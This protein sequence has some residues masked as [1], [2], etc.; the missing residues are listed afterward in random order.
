M[1]VLCSNWMTT[2]S[3]Y[4]G[5]SVKLGYIRSGF[6]YCYVGTTSIDNH[7]QMTVNCLFCSMFKTEQHKIH[8]F[9]YIIRFFFYI[10][11]IDFWII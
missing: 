2:K 10:W 6:Y 5:G 7:D 4:K 8:S 1:A 11:L 9:L 3:V